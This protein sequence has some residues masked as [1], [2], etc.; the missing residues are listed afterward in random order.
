MVIKHYLNGTEIDEPIGFDNLKMTMKRGDY[1]GMSAE[2]SE[3]TLEFYGI[4]ADLIREAYYTDLDTELTYRVTADGE[5]MYSG[6]L[7]LSTYEEQYSDYCSVSCKVGE[8]GIKTTFNNRTDVE[9]DLNG[10]KTIDGKSLAHSYPWEKRMIPYRTIDYRN[11]L[12]QGTTTTYDMLNGETLRLKSANDEEVGM[13]GT[14][15]LNIAFDTISKNEF[16]TCAPALYISDVRGNY[17]AAAGGPN[18]AGYFSPTYEAD[19]ETLKD[20]YSDI[21]VDINVDLWVQF[22]QKPFTNAMIKCCEDPSLSVK[23]AYVKNG[24]YYTIW[25]TGTLDNSTY[26][27][28]YHLGLKDTF[29]CKASELGSLYIVLMIDSNAFCQGITKNNVAAA[30]KVQIDNTS[31]VNITYKSRMEDQVTAD[32]MFVHEALNKVSESISEN[33]LTVKSDLYSRYNSVV[34]PHT[35]TTANTSAFGFYFGDSALKAIT[36]G[37]KIRGLYTTTDKERNMP[38]SFKTLIE[39]L[40]AIDCIGWGF[41]EESGTTYIRVER[42]SWFYKTDDPILVINSPNSVKTSIDTSLIISELAIGYKKYLTNEDIASIDNIMSERTFTT[43]TKAISNSVSKQCEFIAD[44]Y[45][46]ELTRRA[47]KEKEA[48]EEFKYDENVFIFS[49]AAIRKNTIITGYTIDTDISTTDSTILRPEEVYNA[50][51]SPA[52]NAYHWINR[53]FCVAGIKPFT[54]TSGKVNYKAQVETKKTANESIGVVM[55]TTDDVNTIPTYT[56]ILPGGSKIANL[57]QNAENYTL[58]ERYYKTYQ[59]D[60]TGQVNTGIPSSDDVVIPRVFKAETISFTYPLSVAEYKKVKANPYGLIEVD[61]VLGWIKEFT[62]SF[63]DGEATFKLIPK[64][65]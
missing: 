13:V 12:Y 32:T 62:Y 25:Q 41:S 5:E 16:G 6:V 36:N 49:L 31:Y 20:E 30:F 27:G 7:D 10:T 42:W 11:R 3:Q 43:N 17:S 61:G 28:K 15:I 63:A 60:N 35:A 47:A 26:S 53:L 23:I 29:T 65:D 39:A 51:L 9:I 44:N 57:Q 37:Y 8:V 40:D 18:L 50:K 22:T 38:M 52:R 54:C 48:D 34:N 58:R 46:T 55:R 21:E 1:H 45:A 33:A 2:V 64:A 56:Q 4:A 14:N 24:G 19:S 59:L